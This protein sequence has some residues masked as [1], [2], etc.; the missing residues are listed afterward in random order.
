[1]RKF[2]LSSLVSVALIGPALAQT[3]TL[4]WANPTTRTNGQ[5]ITGALTTQIWDLAGS[6]PANLQIG[7]GVSGFKTGQLVAGPHSFT[8]INCE[9]G[10]TCSAPSNV[11]TTTITVL[12]SAPNAVTNLTGTVGP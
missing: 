9:A 1:M 7:T 6:P 3:V 8:V 5:P 10:G 4:M 12:P 2:L 11:F